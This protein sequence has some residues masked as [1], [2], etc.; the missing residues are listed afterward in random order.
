M[1][2]YLAEIGWSAE[3]SSYEL[4]VLIPPDLEES[5][6]TQAVQ[7]IRE[8]VT[9]VGGEVVKE[10]S[11]GKRELAYPIAKQNFASY[12]YFVTNIPPQSVGAVDKKLRVN[13]MVMRHLIVKL[14]AAREKAQQETPSKSKETQ[15]KAKSTQSSKKST[16]KSK[17]KAKAKGG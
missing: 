6:K 1:L 11:W 14:P 2:F 8:I 16:K 7:S 13:E 17:E 9:S 3:M 15:E 5:S 10:E 12:W 4:M